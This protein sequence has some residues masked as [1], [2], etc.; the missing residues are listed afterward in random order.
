MET[1]KLIDCC[2]FISDG[3]H[4]PPP[5]SDSGVPFI[6]ISN[7]TGQNNLLIKLNSILSVAFLH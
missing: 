4:L 5:K 1:K 6:T 7:I 2:E 3:D